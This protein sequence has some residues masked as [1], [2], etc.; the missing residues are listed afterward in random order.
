MRWE[1]FDKD[2]EKQDKLH[3]TISTI[4]ETL[5]AKIRWINEE[6]SKGCE[7]WAV[8][9]NYVGDQYGSILVFYNK[10]EMIGGVGK[11]GVAIQE[12]NKSFPPIL[13]D[14]LYPGYTYLPKVNTILEP[15]IIS[16]AKSYGLN[17]IYA[18]PLFR[19]GKILKKYYGYKEINNYGNE[20]SESVSY[21]N[22]T[23]TDKKLKWPCENSGI[24]SGISYPWMVKRIV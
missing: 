14:I 22:H 21:D 5:K 11:E 3:Y 1:S 23:S 8:I 2:E 13:V 15:G 16:V 20:I 12:I 17:Y 7:I 4:V 10:N 19:Q 24:E 6:M 18:R 9:N